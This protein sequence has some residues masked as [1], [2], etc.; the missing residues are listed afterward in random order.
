MREMQQIQTISQLSDE[1]ENA[2]T[3]S[4]VRD[5][6]WLFRGQSRPYPKGMELLPAIYRRAT[7]LPNSEGW[8]LATDVYSKKAEKEA[9]DHFRERVKN[10]R[11]DM[12]VRKP[13]QHAL[14]WLAL[15]QHHSLPT[16]LLDWTEDPLKALWFALWG[17]YNRPTVWMAPCQNEDI[18]DRRGTGRPMVRPAR[19]RRGKPKPIHDPFAVSGIANRTL[20]FRPAPVSQR[21]KAQDG[22]LALFPDR[23][24]G[25]QGPQTP[26]EKNK[27][28][29][30]D[31]CCFR[32]DPVVRTQM[33][34]ELT[35]Q[36][37]DQSRLFP[38]ADGLS[39]QLRLELQLNA[40]RRK[41]RRV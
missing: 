14:D 39:L 8:A 32:I 5:V 34:R 16:R 37:I 21:I 6:R 26:L 31:V 28:Y 15:A 13:P 41:T 12:G 36:N 2:K 38:D 7:W 11:S 29:R 25:K 9:F 10:S 19:G 22:W 40:F 27:R 35:D 30:D 18:V 23:R 24:S 20:I 17:T 33:Q 1:V 3:N 4:K